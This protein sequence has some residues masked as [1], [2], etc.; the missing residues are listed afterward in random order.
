V[1]DQRRASDASNVGR[2]SQLSSKSRCTKASAVHGRLLALTGWDAGARGRA[3]IACEG[4]S[5]ALAA[6]VG[7]DRKGK[8]SALISAIAIPAALVAPL[9]AVALYVAGGVIW[10]A[11]DRRSRMPWHP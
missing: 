9:V 1:D 7:S 10:F 5:P 11:P 6:A 4:Q 3:F 8:V 2:P